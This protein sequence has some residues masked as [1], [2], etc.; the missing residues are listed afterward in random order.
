MEPAIEG[1]GFG[2][3]RAPEANAYAIAHPRHRQGTQK[4]PLRGR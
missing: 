2:S 1:Y 3:G 4:N